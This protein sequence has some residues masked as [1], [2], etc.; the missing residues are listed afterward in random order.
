MTNASRRVPSDEDPGLEA[1]IAN[2]QRLED[3]ANEF[4]E[5]TARHTA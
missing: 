4:I 2:R 3:M 1:A 5:L